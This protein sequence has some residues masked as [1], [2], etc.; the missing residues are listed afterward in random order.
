MCCLARA[1]QGGLWKVST[2]GKISAYAWFATL[3]DGAVDKHDA[4]AA[5]CTCGG[6]WESAEDGT[7][8]KAPTATPGGT[9]PAPDPGCGAACRRVKVRGRR[10][11]RQSV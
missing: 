8:T 11:L 9:A 4:F 10:W 7:A 1:R 2:Y 5:C 3:D 6:G